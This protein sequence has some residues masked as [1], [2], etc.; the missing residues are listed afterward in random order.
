MAKVGGIGETKQPDDTVHDICHKIRK[1]VEDK[2]GQTFSEFTPI[3]FKTQVVNG[4][5]YFIKVR[6]SDGKYVHIRTHRAFTGE[7]SF[8][9]FEDNKS[10]EEDIGYFH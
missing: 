5:N 7:V 1:D 4:I 2:N 9:N 10:L 3:V 8:A 6:V